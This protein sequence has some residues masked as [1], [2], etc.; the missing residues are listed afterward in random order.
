[1]WGFSRG[2]TIASLVARAVP[3]RVDLAVLASGPPDG[4][5][6]PDDAT[7]ALM[8]GDWGPFVTMAGGMM[9]DEATSQRLL[10]DNDPVAIGAAFRA[11]GQI[12]WGRFEVP[13]VGY[14]GDGEAMRDQA[15]VDARRF[16]FPMAVLPT[17]GH[18]ETFAAVDP[19]MALVAPFLNN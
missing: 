3:E 17:G 15:C 4:S 6:F 10:A 12:Q 11:R 19:T 2:G 14:L 13:V 18:L 7:D 16:G 5:L 1:V 9:G 8:A